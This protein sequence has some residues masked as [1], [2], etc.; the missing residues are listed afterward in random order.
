[1]SDPSPADEAARLLETRPH[2]VRA[3]LL[4]GDQNLAKGDEQT[5]AFFDDTIEHEARNNSEDDRVVLI[6]DVW[7]P[8]LSKQEKSEL[9]ALFSD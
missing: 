5:A 6:F 1:M 2:S 3:H 4:L 9:T 7:R 8:E